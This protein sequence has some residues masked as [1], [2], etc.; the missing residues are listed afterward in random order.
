[1]NIKKILI[2]YSLISTSIVVFLIALGYLDFMHYI[3][4]TLSLIFGLIVYAVSYESYLESRPIYFWL[5]H[6]L[7]YMI[8]RF[9]G[10]FMMFYIVFHSQNPLP[11][12][13]AATVS[14]NANKVEHLHFSDDRD[15]EGKRHVFIFYKH[16]CKVCQKSQA[17]LYDFMQKNPYT[18]DL[19][20]YINI[21]SKK[22][23]ELADRFGLDHA[24]YMVFKEENGQFQIVDRSQDNFLDENKISAFFPIR[25]K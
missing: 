8:F 21:E 17:E 5:T 18:K 11:A 6:I 24:Y 20:T 19:L 13:N 15:F 4:L 7:S 10:F 16:G 23:K 12:T 9:L 22:G 14:L 2:G 25:D 3:A 1:M